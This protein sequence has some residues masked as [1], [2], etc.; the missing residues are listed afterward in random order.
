[1]PAP[2][3][4]STNT[5]DAQAGEQAHQ[6]RQEGA[7]LA[8]LVVHAREAEGELAVARHAVHLSTGRETRRLRPGIPCGWAHGL[9]TMAPAGGAAG[10][11]LRRELTPPLTGACCPH[12]AVNSKHVRVAPAD[13]PGGGAAGR[14]MGH[15]APRPGVPH[16][17]GRRQPR[18]VQLGR[19]GARAGR[20]PGP[21][22]A[23]ATGFDVMSR[24]DIARALRINPALLSFVEQA[25]RGSPADPGVPRRTRL[26]AEAVEQWIPTRQPQDGRRTSVPRT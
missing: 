21:A 2:L 20:E 8:G 24:E 7:P 1:M 16:R 5:S 9:L 12:V 18:A 14:S 25:S 4:A 15:R 17:P 6:R 23:P 3:P 26:D 10:A 22:K 11:M 19:S 13:R